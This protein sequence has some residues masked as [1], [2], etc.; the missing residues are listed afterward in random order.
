MLFLPSRTPSA[1]VRWPW[2]S[3]PPGVPAGRQGGVP[4]GRV[5][6]ATLG[7]AGARGRPGGRDYMSTWSLLASSGLAPGARRGGGGG[8]WTAPAVPLRPPAVPERA[9]DSPLPVSSSSF[10]HT[11]LCFNLHCNAQGQHSDLPRHINAG[12]GCEERNWTLRKL[13]G[14][15]ETGDKNT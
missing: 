9:G 4:I 6:E 8:R 15:G 14:T 10:D 13:T 5:R 11:V 12:R 2:R 1:G 7:R 3:D